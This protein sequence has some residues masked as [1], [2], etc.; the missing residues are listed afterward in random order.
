[1]LGQQGVEDVRQTVGLVVDDVRDFH[2][3]GPFYLNQVG[4][5][6]SK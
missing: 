6:D 3:L 1:M 4:M 5:L 2:E